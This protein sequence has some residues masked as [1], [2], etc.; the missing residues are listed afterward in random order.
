MVNI[1]TMPDA[2]YGHQHA[3]S[4]TCG[5]TLLLQEILCLMSG[6]YSAALTP[7]ARVFANELWHRVGANLTKSMVDGHRG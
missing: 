2:F 6:T 5:E 1:A 4:L 3:I 7:G